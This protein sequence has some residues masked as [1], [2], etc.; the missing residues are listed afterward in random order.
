[1]PLACCMERHE[2][3]HLGTGGGGERERVAP[4]GVFPIPEMDASIQVDPSDWLQSNAF[5][6][7]DVDQ[8]VYDRINEA[9]G[10]NIEMRMKKYFEEMEE[11]R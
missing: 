7:T 2:G 1:M 10:T 4:A 6:V 9:Y 5:D 8:Q 11:S 3:R